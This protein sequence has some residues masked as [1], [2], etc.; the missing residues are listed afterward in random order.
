MLSSLCVIYR[1]VGSLGRHRILGGG[2]GRGM[3]AGDIGRGNLWWLHMLINVLHINEHA[4]CSQCS[5]DRYVS[6]S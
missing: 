4:R 1:L 6:E 5:Y 2:K 3:G